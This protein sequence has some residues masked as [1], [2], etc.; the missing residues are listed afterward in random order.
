MQAMMTLTTRIGG[1]EV[2]DGVGVDGSPCHAPPF[3]A[4][5]TCW[6]GCLCEEKSCDTFHSAWPRFNSVHIYVF[7]YYTALFQ[8]SCL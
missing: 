3:L 7:M 8:F 1:G 2:V 6:V 4:P 5:A